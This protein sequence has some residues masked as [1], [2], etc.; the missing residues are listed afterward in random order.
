MSGSWVL[1]WWALGCIIERWDFLFRKA[2]SMFRTV[3]W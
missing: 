1:S 3:E 2:K